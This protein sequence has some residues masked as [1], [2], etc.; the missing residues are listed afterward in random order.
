V[1]VR[2]F[3]ELIWEKGR[4]LYRDMPWRDDT[5]PYYVLVSEIMLQQ[6][7]V[8]RVIPK[9]SEFIERF[10]TVADLAKAPLSDVLIV[11]SGLGYNRRAKYLH[12][13]AGKIVADFKGTIPKELN[14]LITLPGIGPNTAGAILA[15]SFN[16]PVTFVET[17]IRTV[18]FHHFFKDQSS[19]S[20]RELKEVIARTVDHEH[21]REW[22]W[23]LMDYGALLK[24]QG[25]G[26]L[27][28]SAQYRKQA[29]LKGSL[30]EVRGMI[31][32]SLTVGDVSTKALAAT[33]PADA[34]FD[35]ALAALLAEGL[36]DQ[37]SNRLH[38]RR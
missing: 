24:K 37:T 12:E 23:A 11:W 32:K 36:V 15:Y 33:M 7:Q 4:E 25:L 21:P 38:L 6:T 31:L 16:Q 26:R 27:D 22:Y 17:N 29:P 2:E 28:Q 5:N 13:A 34:R 20:D 8:D 9:F 30:R 19:V 10:P 3:Q 18:Y 1:N 14:Q 35:Q